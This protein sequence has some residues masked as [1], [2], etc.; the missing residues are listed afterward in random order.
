MIPIVE[1]LVWYVWNV[2]IWRTCGL[3]KRSMPTFYSGDWT[4]IQQTGTNR[5]S[6]NQSAV[7]CILSSRNYACCFRDGGVK[8]TWCSLIKKNH[9][10]L[11]VAHYSGVCTSNRAFGCDLTSSWSL[12]FILCFS[13]V[14]PSRYLV[15]HRP[16]YWFSLSENIAVSSKICFP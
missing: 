10:L 14:Y 2:Q 12:N 4:A 3:Q 6:V 16:S 11:Y 7:L 8:V 15:K 13:R 1:M 5:I 9:F